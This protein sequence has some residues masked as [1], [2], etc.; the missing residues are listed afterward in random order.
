MYEFVTGQILGLD[1][2]IN[3]SKIIFPAA[4]STRDV[5]KLRVLAFVGEAVSLPD[6]YFQPE[7]LWPPIIWSVAFMVVNAAR[8][9]ATAWERRPAVLSEKEEKLYRAAFRSID[10]R[11]FL[12]LVSLAEWV[13]CLPGDIILQKGKQASDAFVIVSGD[14]DAVFSGE[15]TIALGPGQLVGSASAYSGLASQADVVA[16][17]PGLLAR[18]DLGQLRDFAATKPELRAT[19]LRIVS[20]DLA[21]K[22]RN[23]A[24]AVSSH[25]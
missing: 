23:V 15:T 24:T 12:R 21:A 17:G 6:F 14:F 2:L 8:I 18:W 25:P 9:G 11:E 5:L 10:R 7:S 19:L 22:L 1:G 16:R 13:D 3:L 4:Y 20:A